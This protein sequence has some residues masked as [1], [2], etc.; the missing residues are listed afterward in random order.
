MFRSHAMVG[1][2]AFLCTL[3]S[4]PS[5]VRA[6]EDDRPAPISAAQYAAD[7]AASAQL[8]IKREEH[9]DT[10]PSLLNTPVP[11]NDRGMRTD[12]EGKIPLPPGAENQVDSAVQGL[13]RAPLPATPAPI[14]TVDGVGNGF[15]GPQGLFV[16]QYIPPDTNGAIGSRQYVQTVNDNLA[17]FDK[18]TKAVVYGPVPENILWTGFGGGCEANN[19]GDPVVVYDKA[20]DRW[21]VSQ[22]S[23]STTP[24]LQ[25]VAVSQTNDAT[26]AWNRYAFSYTNFPDYPKMG[27]WPDGYYETFNMFNGNSFAGANLC[28]YDR[29]AMLAGTTAT[30]QC[31]QLASSFG[32]VLPSDLDGLTQPPA[33]APNYLVNFG[34]N[35]LN[36]WKFHVDWATP[37]NTTLSAPISIPVASFNPACAGGICVP[38]SGTKK[39]IDSLGDRLMFRLAY[40]NFGA[41]ESLVVSHSVRVGTGKNQ[42]TGV[43]WYELRSP[44]ST[45]I[46]YQQST[47]SPDALL[48]RW[49]PSI[50]MD[51]DGNIALGYSTSSASAFPSIAYTARLAT[52]TLSTMGSEV[53]MTA[54]GGA[55][56]GNRWGDYSAM[57]VDPSDDC[58]F[59]YTNE[60]LVASANLTNKWSTSIG[61]FKFPSCGVTGA[62]AKLE[63]KVQP[64]ASYTA[65]GNIMV[66]VAVEDGAGKIVTTDNSAVTLVLSGGNAGAILSGTNPVNAVS[67]V[68]TFNLAVDKSGANY[69]LNASDAALSGT[70]STSFNVSAGAPASI[71]FSAGPTNAVAGTANNTPTGIIVHVQDGGANPIVGDNVTLSVASGPGSVTVTNPQS[72]DASGNATFSD[73]VLT[74]AGNYTIKA[75]ENGASLNTTSSSFIIGPAAPQLAFTTQPVDVAQGSTLNTIAVTKQDVYGNVYGSDT[76][77]I[78]FSVASCGGVALGSVDLSGGVATLSSNPPRFYTA[79]AGLQVTATDTSS[80]ISGLSQ[81]FGVIS[82]IDLLYSDGFDGCRL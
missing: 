64:N 40:R 42:Q 20:A 46:V 11:P 43:R 18:A 66:K 25:C 65:G 81:T 63:F 80:A 27:V 37:A 19:D 51:G 4:A 9:H 41:N 69:V 7:M 28:A 36:L 56:S 48:Y 58:T 71:A 6:E 55:Q 35:S 34:T 72:T 79:A 82:N 60:Y 24:Y 50:A 38:Q 68:A 3:V 22:F 1:A 2:L 15:T 33:G 44:G 13:T 14:S 29:T 31:F 5:I 26:G 17:V 23:V 59:W 32:G 67:G 61:S 76:D 62:P 57:T 75:I 47:Y 12:F 21:V 49:M 16:N 74:V 30:Q 8:T 54:G 73:A 53:V 77:Q 10:L 45:P 70:A 39:Q 52:D 78:D